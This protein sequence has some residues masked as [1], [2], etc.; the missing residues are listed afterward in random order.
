MAGVETFTLRQPKALRPDG[1]GV[2]N[3]FVGDLTSFSEC[4]DKKFNVAPMQ[5]LSAFQEN[6][7]RKLTK[8]II[9]I[10]GAD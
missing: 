9:F 1:K 8:D 10:P 2:L 6:K 5:T 3:V 4:R 7:K